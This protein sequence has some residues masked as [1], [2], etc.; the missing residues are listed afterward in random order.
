[1]ANGGVSDAN[2]PQSFT[3]RSG[4]ACAIQCC[5]FVSLY[6]PVPVCLRCLSSMY[7]SHMPARMTGYLIPNISVMLKRISGEGEADELEWRGEGKVAVLVG[8]RW[9]WRCERLGP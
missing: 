6:R 7:L 3:G 9:G 1:M 8:M 2:R 4:R 5:A